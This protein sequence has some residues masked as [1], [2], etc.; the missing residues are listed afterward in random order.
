MSSRRYL[1]ASTDSSTSL[2]CSM[3][4]MAFVSISFLMMTL[5][6]FNKVVVSLCYFVLPVIFALS[7]LHSLQSLTLS[8]PSPRMTLVAFSNEAFISSCIFI[9]SEIRP[10]RSSSIACMR[11]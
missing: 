1:R 4:S 6:L 8:S 7:R 3:R 2:R 11:L 10:I 9:Q 5:I